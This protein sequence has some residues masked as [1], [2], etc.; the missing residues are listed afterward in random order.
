MRKTVT[1]ANVKGRKYSE[2]KVVTNKG[3]TYILYIENRD[4]VLSKHDGKSSKKINIIK[5]ANPYQTS[6]YKKNNI[7]YLCWAVQGGTASVVKCYSYN[8]SDNILRKLFESD[9]ID[10]MNIEDLRVVIDNFDNIFI[11][12]T[13]W[14]ESGAVSQYVFSKYEDYFE[15]N[16]IDR[17]GKHGDIAVDDDYLHLVWQKKASKNSYI[18][19]YKKKENKINGKWGKV[20]EIAG[21]LEN[22]LVQRPRCSL[23][24]HILHVIYHVGE[25]PNR[26]IFY[27]NSQDN[28]KSKILV[29]GNPAGYGSIDICS[30][31]EHNIFISMKKGR[32]ILYNRMV[33][34]RWLGIVALLKDKFATQDS[35]LDSDKFSVVFC[36]RWQDVR[37]V[38]DGKL[39]YEEE[40][41]A[42]APEEI[43]NSEPEITPIPENKPEKR[44]IDD[45]KL[46][47]NVIPI[48]KIEKAESEKIVRLNLKKPPFIFIKFDLFLKKYWSQMLFFVTGFVLKWLLK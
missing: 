43:V 48:M 12:F 5:H 37:L 44:K 15:K 13:V 32:Q 46:R 1:I 4:L 26:Q 35:F 8:I 38:Q 9:T 28:F 47:K 39:E 10:C 27:K 6:L 34:G 29:S 11:T 25:D 23:S 2:P 19:G 20:K 16:I 33:E 17:R 22:G 40:D 30:E 24:G 31:N 41:M 21:Q 36:S 7:L 18:I 3:D 14:Q 45:E 42:P